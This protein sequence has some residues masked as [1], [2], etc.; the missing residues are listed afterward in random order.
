MG[1]RVM[2][3]DNFLPWRGRKAE[4]LEVIKENTDKNLKHQNVVLW[5]HPTSQRSAGRLIGCC[6]LFPSVQVKGKKIKGELS[7]K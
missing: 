5:F 6:K 1:K 4:S 3:V 2:N 7:S